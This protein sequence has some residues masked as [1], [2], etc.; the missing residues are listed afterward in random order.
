[1]QLGLKPDVATAAPASRPILQDASAA[2]DVLSR[3]VV[4]GELSGLVLSE[5]GRLDPS[6]LQTNFN[7]LP[8][9]VSGAIAFAEEAPPPLP[10]RETITSS[11]GISTKWVN[12]A[13]CSA[14]ARA[15]PGVTRP[16]RWLPVPSA[17]TS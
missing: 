3:V 12:D 6:I 1:M 14:R 4:A 7:Q 17:A 13:S 16:P 15:N 11:S 2:V 8:V 5:P 9:A 10:P